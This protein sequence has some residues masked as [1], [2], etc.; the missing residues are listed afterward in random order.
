MC[1]GENTVRIDFRAG[2][3]PSNR[4]AD[5]LCTRFVPAHARRAIPCFD[6]PD[7]EGRWTVSLN[8]PAQCLSVAHDAERDRQTTGDR[9]CVLFHPTQPLPS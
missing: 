3:G 7:L 4:G 8:H 6:Q 2:D 9:V 1:R 5:V